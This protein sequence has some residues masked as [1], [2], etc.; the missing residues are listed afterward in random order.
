MKKTYP[1]YVKSLQKYGI[2]TPQ[3]NY[4]SDFCFYYFCNDCKRC[5]ITKPQYL[6]DKRKKCIHCN[7][8]NITDHT[9]Q[10]QN[11]SWMGGV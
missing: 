7:S 4:Q 11:Y 5:S 2:S 10:N 9:L 8:E 6:K 3:G 1:S